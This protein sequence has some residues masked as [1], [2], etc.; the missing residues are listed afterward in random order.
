MRIDLE[1]SLVCSTNVGKVYNVRVERLHEDKGEKD[2][3]GE[4]V[5]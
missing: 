1:L 2:R 4:K 3:F 5:G